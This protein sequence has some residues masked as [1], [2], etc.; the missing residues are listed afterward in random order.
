MCEDPLEQIY[1]FYHQVHN[2]C[3]ISSKFPAL[4]SWRHNGLLSNG[5]GGG[6][7]ATGCELRDGLSDRA[8]GGGGGGRRSPKGTSS[9]H[10]GG[11]GGGEN[12]ELMKL[13]FIDP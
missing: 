2:I 8:G 7:G 1:R 13:G 3:K 6:G 5:G 9:G 4:K 10:G 12:V 11:V